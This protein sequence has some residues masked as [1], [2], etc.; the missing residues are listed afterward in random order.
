MALTELLNLAMETHNMYEASD[1][2]IFTAVMDAKKVREMNTEGDE[3]SNDLAVPAELGP[4]CKE[5]LQASLLLQEFVSDMD[6]PFACNLEVMLCS[7]GHRT[8][9]LSMQGMENSKIT[10]YFTRE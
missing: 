6:S 4:T 10:D 9:V 8:R 3:V 1:E 7:F 5:A 2:D